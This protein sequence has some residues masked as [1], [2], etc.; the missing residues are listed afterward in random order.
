MIKISW[1]CCFL[2][3]IT[4]CHDVAQLPPGGGSR[5][6]LHLGSSRSRK[7]PG[8]FWEKTLRG[9]EQTPHRVCLFWLKLIFEEKICIYFTEKLFA[10][11]KVSIPFFLVNILCVSFSSVH[12]FQERL[13]GKKL[14][15][16]QQP[17]QVIATRSLSEFGP[18]IWILLVRT[19]KDYFLCNKSVFPLY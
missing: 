9:T 16:L 11:L 14:F 8:F 2:S 1:W 7:G 17:A 15:T 12:F 19:T 6:R 10:G 5:G 3:S 4:S 13:A 18:K